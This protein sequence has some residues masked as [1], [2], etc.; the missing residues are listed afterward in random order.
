MVK[1]PAIAALVSGM[2]MWFL[3]AYMP[4]GRA[5]C[6]HGSNH[7]DC[8]FPPWFTHGTRLMLV[9]CT[10]LST[11]GITAAARSLMNCSDKHDKACKLN[12]VFQV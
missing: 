6:F 2:G 4:Q 5:I 10:G 12:Q 1:L 11:A 3:T 7:T 9:L 8:D